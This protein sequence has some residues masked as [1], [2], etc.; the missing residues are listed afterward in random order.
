MSSYELTKAID[1]LVEKR[2]F[3]LDALEAIKQLRDKAEE[4]EVTLKRRDSEIADILAKNQQLHNEVSK[5]SGQLQAIETR[6][7]A[8][9]AREKDADKAV[10][11]A[12]KQK[13]VADT[14]RWAFETTMRPAAVRTSIQRNVAVPVAGSDHWVGFVAN[15]NE[16]E[17]TTVIQE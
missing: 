3:S 13:A 9:A 7:S 8:V 14:L 11:E 1:A 17:T 16:T 6:E 15:G 10:Y 12:D 4:Q 5:L 2:T